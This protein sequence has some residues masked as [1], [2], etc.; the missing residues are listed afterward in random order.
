M[1][2]VVTV[3]TVRPDYPQWRDYLPLL[4]S[5]RDTALCFGHEHYIVSDED[6]GAEFWHLK[7]ELPQSLMKAMIAGVIHR[8]KQGGDSHLVFVDADCLVGRDLAGAFEYDDFDLGL[9]RRDNELSPINNGAMYVHKDGISKALTFFEYALSFC[10]DHWGAD[11][12][13]ISAAAYPVPPTPRVED[14]SGMRLNFMSMRHHN[15]VPKAQFMRHKSYPF[16]VHFKGET[17]KWMI[18]YANRYILKV[19]ASA[20]VTG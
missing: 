17:K 4:R 8:L 9:T 18:D 10:G 7:T 2:E 19:A 16:I 14:R 13:A 11:Q 5:Q 3:F 15:A 20:S 1:I 6:L 12:E